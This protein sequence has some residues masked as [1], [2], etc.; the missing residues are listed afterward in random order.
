[1]PLPRS[2]IASVRLRLPFGAS[3]NKQAVALIHAGRKACVA[4]VHFD[5]DH[6]WVAH[7]CLI[8]RKRFLFFP[9]HAAWLLSPVINTSA[10]DIVRFSESDR[11]ELINCLGGTEVVLEAGQGVLFPSM[12]W[13]GVLHEEPSLAVSVRFEPSPAGRPFAVLPRSWLFQ[14][15]VWRL[16]QQGYGSVADEFLA[17]YLES[18]FRYTKGWKSRY[19]R[20]AE[21]C[22]K[23][24]M[25]YGEQQ[26]VFNLTGENFSTEMALASDELKLYYGNVLKSQ[27]TIDSEQVKEVHSYIFPSVDRH[28]SAHDL[29]LAL[30][31]LRVRQGLPPKRGVVQIEQE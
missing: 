3:W 1:M 25:Q 26:G 9:P 28:P 6:K 2:F 18:F 21:L 31:A 7:A 8:G 24:L 17:E 10:L 16:F 12:F 14:R 27:E 15:L 20:S 11:S 30:Y 29:H 19:R 4:P 22:K 5:W 23:A 13:H